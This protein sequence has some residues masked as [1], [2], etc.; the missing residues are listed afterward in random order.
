MTQYAVP[1]NGRVYAYY[2]C[3][4]L[5]R[6]GKDGCSPDRVR[7]NHRAEEVEQRVWE[8]VSELTRDPEQLREDLERMIELERRAVHGNPECEM[9]AWL[10]KLTEVDSERRGY[11]RLAARG[12]L[13]D[14]ELDEVLAELEETRATAERELATLRSRQRSIEALEQDRDALLEH[15][16]AIAPEA[17]DS[18]TPEERHQ[19]YKMLRLTVVIRPDTA[20]EVSGVFG[21]ELPV[22]NQKLVSG[23]QEDLARHLARALPSGV[24]FG[25]P[26]G[27]APQER[28][29]PGD[30]LQ[31]LVGPL[32][33]GLFCCRL[34]PCPAQDVVEHIGEDAG[35]RVAHEWSLDEGPVDDGGT[36]GKGGY[37]KGVGHALF[38]MCSDDEV[39]P[40]GFD[41]GCGLLGIVLNESPFGE[42]VGVE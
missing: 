18:L 6:F 28:R 10:D 37:S 13:T 4:R 22:S 35:T 9:K 21:E 29:H 12:N 33:P 30:L 36:Q 34:H 17:L 38:Q 40:C 7:T 5:L 20:L 26:A 41:A 8:S 15:L 24:L 3:A 1:R 25:A 19:L 39:G 16:A 32:Y 31:R 11:I 23:L 27:P 2:K 14:R 42:S